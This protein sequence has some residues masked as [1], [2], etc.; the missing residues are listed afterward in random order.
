MDV[1]AIVAVVTADAMTADEPMRPA[2]V[3][4]A[5]PILSELRIS[6]TLA[7]QDHPTSQTWLR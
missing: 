5:N 6:R 7:I 4:P 2:T 3:S 1:D